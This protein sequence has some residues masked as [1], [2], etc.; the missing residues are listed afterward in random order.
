MRQQHECTALKKHER[1]VVAY[2]DGC[3]YLPVVQRSKATLCITLLNG[4]TLT[5]AVFCPLTVSEETFPL[6]QDLSQVTVVAMG[7]LHMHFVFVKGCLPGEF[8][9]PGRRWITR[10]LILPIVSNLAMQLRP[11]SFCQPSRFWTFG[12]LFLS[13]RVVVCVCVCMCASVGTS[14]CAC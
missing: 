3:L 7:Q 6:A 11:L 2:S 13:V 8:I 1:D 12:S 10:F 4:L 5:M 14:A 9:Y